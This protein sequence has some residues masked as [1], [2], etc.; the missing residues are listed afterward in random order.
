MKIVFPGQKIKL[1]VL[2]KENSIV[3]PNLT[4]LTVEGVDGNGQ[5]VLL[6]QSL[7]ENGSVPGLYEY[8]W[9]G[10]VTSN[11]DV[12]TI[13]FIYYKKAAELILMEEYFFDILEDQDG[14]A[15]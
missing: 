15:V 3:V 8:T 5:S 13:V 4:D 11:I 12:E 7:I 10:N 6:S 9:L 14:A 2:Y 1:W